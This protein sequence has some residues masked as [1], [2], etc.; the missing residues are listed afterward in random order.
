M[1]TIL[2]GRYRLLGEIGMGG[3]AR[4]FRA[5]DEQRWK[6]VA[7]KYLQPPGKMSRGQAM[8]F[9]R[10]IAVVSQLHHPHIVGFLGAHFRPPSCYIVSEY[11]QG[12]SLALILDRLTRLPA[13]LALSV[14][15]ELFS[16]LEYIHSQGFIHADLSP[17]N[18][19]VTQSGI[20]Q[21]TDFGLVRHRYENSESVLFGTPGYYSPEHVK[22][23]ELAPKSDV[24]SLA[25]IIFECLSGQRA[26]PPINDR[27]SLLIFMDAI[28]FDVIRSSDPIRTVLLREL[29]KALL[30]RS[31]FS[32]VNT[33]AEARLMV[34]KVMNACRIEYVVGSLK[35]LLTEMAEKPKRNRSVFRSARAIS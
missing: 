5:M 9:Y 32:R 4:V 28:P 26:I 12:A 6:I 1:E 24:F 19:L 14:A 33:A 7:I 10:E 8:R 22:L 34:A 21:L 17:S 2:G 16:A 18:I 35:I 11:V 13:P 3:S 29:M 31:L 30:D 20:A 25:M 15:F 27:K 23:K